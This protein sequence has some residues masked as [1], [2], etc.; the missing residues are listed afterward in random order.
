MEVY[1]VVLGV[2]REDIVVW[3]RAMLYGS[4]IDLKVLWLKIK[5]C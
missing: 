4:K 2:F 3:G 1:W 5:E